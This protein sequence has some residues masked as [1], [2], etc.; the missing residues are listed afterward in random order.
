[1]GVVKRSRGACVSCAPR[2][3]RHRSECPECSGVV[4]I[5]VEA[6]NAD[7]HQVTVAFCTDCEFC[8]EV[9]L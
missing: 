2:V 6:R 7:G 8:T 3:A 5:D 9:S 4:I 1:V